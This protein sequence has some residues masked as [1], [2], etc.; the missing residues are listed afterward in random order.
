MSLIKGSKKIAF[1]VSSWASNE[2]LNSFKQHLSSQVEVFTKLD[3]L[4]LN[5]T[6]EDKILIKADKNP[7]SDT[8]KSLFGEKTFSDQGEFDLLVVWGEGFGFS[9]IRPNLKTIYLTPYHDEQIQSVTLHLPLSTMI[10]RKGS[11]T[12]FEGKTNFFEPVFEKAKEVFHAEELFALIGG[13]K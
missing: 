5:E 11:F 6:I 12:N 3:R 9:S 7:N 8:V 4:P 2:E 13:G 1:V 10:E